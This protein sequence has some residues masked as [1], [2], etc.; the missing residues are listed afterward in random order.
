M[1]CI[2]L[3]NILSVKYVSVLILLKTLIYAIYSEGEQYED[4]NVGLHI[5]LNSIFKET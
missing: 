4:E 5:L 1:L 2:K 3:I